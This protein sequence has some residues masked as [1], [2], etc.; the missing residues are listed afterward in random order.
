MKKFLGILSLIVLF[1]VSSKFSYAQNVTREEFSKVYADYRAKYEEYVKSHDTYILSKKLYDQYKTL[2]SKEN[3]QKD[4][5][6]MLVKRDEVLVN[7]YKSI[8]SK[9]EDSSITISE[10]RKSEYSG[11]LNSEI[12]WLEE[13]KALYKANDSPETLSIK[14][15]EV[16]TRYD[17][18]QADLYKGLYYLARGKAEKY[19][20]RYNFLFNDLYSLTE[21]VKNEQREAYKL[22][23]TKMEIIERWFGEITLKNDEFTNLLSKAD[24]SILKSSGKT[25]R[26]TYG[27][28]VK[29]L[30]D[31]MVVFHTR[32]GYTQ[33]I[34]KEIKVSESEI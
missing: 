6:N 5:Q 34:I 15:A 24:E 16:L 11:K 20:E 23:D 8:I 28:S 3:L 19:S 26:V 31:A 1:F 32:L 30:K 25:S 12:L 2:S 9:M 33:E 7:Y 13:H 14:S 22:S 27:G 10:E 17:S 4:T 18:F 29:I 21:K